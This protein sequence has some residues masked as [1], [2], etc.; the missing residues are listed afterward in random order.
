MSTARSEHGSDIAASFCHQDWWIDRGW[1]CPICGWCLED[2]IDQEIMQIMR[3]IDVRII[4]TIACDNGVGA[5]QQALG[6]AGCIMGPG[7]AIKVTIT[8]K[9]RWLVQA[10]T[11]LQRRTV[12]RWTG[13]KIIYIG[14]YDPVNRMK[15]VTMDHTIFGIHHLPILERIASYM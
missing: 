11:I 14:W 9:W 7:F 10:R 15:I 13:N 5:L 6:E 8:A 4:T 12:P 2:R 3:R 1:H